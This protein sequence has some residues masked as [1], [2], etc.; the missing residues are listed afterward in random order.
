MA[1]SHISYGAAG[2]DHAVLITAA[3][4]KL[5]EG[6]EALADVIATMALMLNGDGTDEAH[7]T[8]YV[9]DKFGFPDAATAK[10]GWDELNSVHGKLSGDGN[11]SFVNA[12]LNQ[13]FNKFR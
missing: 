2:A 7:F 8:A 12:A 13:F 4:N 11:V 1:I 10:A 6:K 3:K 5:E 9:I